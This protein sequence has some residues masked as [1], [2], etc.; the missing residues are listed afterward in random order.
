MPSINPTLTGSGKALISGGAALGIL[1]VAPKLTVAGDRV[2]FDGA[3][4]VQRIHHAGWVG[5]GADTG[6]S[7][8]DLITWSTFLRYPYED[9]RITNGVTFADTYFWDLTPGTTIELEIDW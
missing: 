6:A 7:P 3:G 2:D 5:I 8:P 4:S 9:F 1:E